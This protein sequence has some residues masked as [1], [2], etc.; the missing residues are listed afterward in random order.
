MKKTVMAALT[1]VTVFGIGNGFSR[2]RWES[3]I[4][5]A[6][7]T[8]DNTLKMTDRYEG[9][10]RLISRLYQQDAMERIVYVDP[11]AAG[12]ADGSSWM[13]AF[14]TIQAALDALGENGGWVWVAEGEYPESIRLKS[15]TSL[16]G[17]FSGVEADIRDRDASRHRTM[18]IGDTTRSVVFMEHFTL[19]DGFTIENGGGEQGGGV[20]TGGWLS[21]IR[22]N[23]IHDNHVSWSGG[24]ICV[25]GGWPADASLG[26]VDGMAPLIERNLIYRNTGQCGSGITTR[27]APTL[28]VNNTLTN[29]N[30]SERSRGI[31]VLMRP[32][33]EPTIINNILWNHQDEVYYQVGSTGAP[34]FEYNCVKDIEPG[35]GVIHE[36]PVFAD[37]TA[38][39]FHLA[40]GSPCIDAG[41]RSVFT[42]PDGSPSDMGAF[43]FF[44]QN[45]PR[46]GTLTLQSEPVSGI[47][48]HVDDNPLLTPAGV[49]WYPGF[50]HRIE[51][52]Q[53]LFVGY[54]TAY[55]FDNWQDGGD[56]YRWVQSGES[57]MTLTARYRYQYRLDITNRPP[58]AAVTGDGWYDPHAAATVSA[59]TPLAEAD[60][61]RQVFVRWEGGGIGSYTGANPLFHVTMNGPIRERL[62][63]RSEYKLETSIIPAGEAG[64]RIT[65]DRAGP[66]YA[67]GASVTLRGESTDPHYRFAYWDQ[68]KPNPDGSLTLTMDGP[69]A[70]KG[71]FAYQPHP[72]I[73]AGLPDT[74]LQEDTILSIPWTWLAAHIHDDN[75]P[76]PALTVSFTPTP[77]LAFVMDTAAQ[78]LRIIPAKDWNGAE[79]VFVRVTDPT[80]A[81][82]QAATVITVTPVDD[83]PRPFDLI[84]PASDAVPA[85]TGGKIRFSWTESL[86]VDEKDTITYRLVIGTSKSGLTGSAVV[87]LPSSTTTL[88]VAPPPAGT[89]YWSV[90]ASDRKNN[91]VWAGQIN[92]LKLTTDVE[93]EKTPLPSRFDVSANYPNPFN[94]ETAFEIQL[95][96]DS[97]VSVMVFDMRGQLVRSLIEGEQTAGTHRVSW[98][99]RD[100]SGRSMPSGLYSAR[101]Q[102]GDRM[103]TRKLMLAK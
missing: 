26:K 39:D 44:R 53:F 79:T 69:R 4:G 59:Q 18:L 50:S 52:A 38:G 19:L 41:T 49:S 72:P 10:S 36:D 64:L 45:D 58:G 6:Y 80:G 95:P 25:V 35:D 51:A 22:N 67:A 74:T 85:L 86:N 71:F 66:W 23:V 60:G 40:S 32:L 29:N 7:S 75:D 68:D 2:D 61:A 84:S 30:G 65:V 31:E 28:I 43:C 81:S 94:P 63:Y 102:L 34:I 11:R 9:Y 89:Y 77:H 33:V 14:G 15:K 78:A 1:L 42:D 98:D 54:G 3:V 56:R 101:I 76:L 90:L 55:V 103:F 16:F 5:Y 88:N 37:T 83:P 12:F 48:V 47:T 93:T 62:V 46:G 92:R 73:I 21:I 17:G 8:F 24:G 96:R 70:V 87:D 97:R 91:E 20:C 82:A 100:S 99:G 13:N 27:Y 57:P